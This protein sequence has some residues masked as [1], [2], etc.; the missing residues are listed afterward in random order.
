M[1]NGEDLERILIVKLGSIGDVVHTLPT[2]NALR[3]T[4]PRS[5]ISWL[6]E[7]ASEEIL[8]GH[9][10][11]DEIIVFERDKSSIF[12]TV[13]AFLQLV[14]KL[15]NRKFDI[16]LDLQAL[17]K[18]GIITIL[19]GS[20]IKVGFEAG[21]SRA[22]KMSHLFTNVKVKEGGFPHILERNLQ[23]ARKLGSR[24]SE[25]RFDIP[26]SQNGRKYIDS[27][28][29]R[30]SIYDKR[31]I[32]LHP[33]AG[34]STKKWSLGK[35][36]KLADEISS[37]FR[38]VSVILTWGPG[39]YNSVE[40]IHRMA[41]SGPIMAPKTT[42]GQ[43][44][45]LLKRCKVLVSSDT[46]PLHIAAALGKRVIGLYGP[47]DSIRNGPYGEGNFIIKK[48]MDCLGCWRKKCNR[49]D[50]MKG[51]QVSDVLEK[52]DICLRTVL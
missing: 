50:C 31:I 34:W 47:T 26:V 25:I 2:L 37:N 36:A 17:I 45:P 21:S 35:Y 27:F 51:I 48:E 10:S 14:K 8:I 13:C 44:I 5:Y 18:S 1:L 12:K 52:V 39:E 4:F 3:K 9:P 41:R 30:E 40:E 33:G 24:V 43:L 6:V 46:G 15:R 19:S 16:T 22:E 11:L 28:L 42:I 29:K 38:D 7:P 20:K 49:L 32:I 23:F